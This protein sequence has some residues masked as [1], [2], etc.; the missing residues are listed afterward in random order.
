MN[1]IRSRACLRFAILILTSLFRNQ[2]FA[3]CAHS[4]S[5]KKLNCLICVKLG[6]HPIPIPNK[7]QVLIKIKAFGLSRSELFTRLGY[8]PNVKLTRILGIEAVD[9]IHEAR[10][11]EFAKGN[12]IATCMGSLG[13][14]VDGGHAEYTLIKAEYARAMRTDLSWN[15]LGALPEMLQTW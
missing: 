14:E 15:V 10:G 4:S 9:H 11:G 7:G 2:L 3:V 12:V 6:T 1:A 5:A 8:S 13:R